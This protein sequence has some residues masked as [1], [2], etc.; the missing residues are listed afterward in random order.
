MSDPNSYDLLA[1]ALDWAQQQITENTAQL[2]DQ[3]SG[4]TL[5]QKQRLEYANAMLHT[6]IARYENPGAGNA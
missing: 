3:Y 2:A 6:F 5:V 4:L 1:H